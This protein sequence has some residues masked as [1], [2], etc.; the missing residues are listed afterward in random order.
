MQ[1]I[2]SLILFLGN[3][4]PLHMD[5]GVSTMK[6]EVTGRKVLSLNST[7]LYSNTDLI[8]RDLGVC[9][10]KNQA[11]N[12]SSRKSLTGRSHQAGHVLQNVH[13]TLFSEESQAAGQ[14]K[15]NTE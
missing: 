12:H 11:E 7:L 10:L 14:G 6:Q 15:N 5:L 4:G 9:T 1:D 8:T 3:C 2:K 13:T